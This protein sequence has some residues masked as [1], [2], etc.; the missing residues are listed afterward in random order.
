MEFDC[1]EEG[2]NVQWPHIFTAM[3][4]PFDRDGN[5]DAERAQILARWLVNHGSQGLVLA[6]TTGESPTLANR[7]RARLWEAVRTAVGADVPVLM[8]TG[9]NDTE[10]ARELSRE[11][12]QWGVDG[13]LLVTPYYNKP[14]QEGLY[15]HFLRIAD[16]LPVPVMLYNVPGRT[17]VHLEADTIRRIVADAPNVAA[18]KEA[19]GVLGNIERLLECCPET[20]IYSGDD[21][22]FYPGLTMGAHGVVSVAAH[23]VGTEMLRL[24]EAFAQGDIETARTWHLRLLPVFRGLFRLPNP[25]PVKWVLNR[26]GLEVGPVRLPLVY[27]DDETE[28]EELYTRVRAITEDPARNGEG[29]DETDRC[30]C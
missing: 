7:E 29:K 26:M 16:D 21:A 3:A 11:A 8:G 9:S 28:L 14:P 17:G 23:V 27:P 30:A 18:V 6:G 15:R 12:A 5:L 13:V 22:L 4:T 2:I 19:S 1:S 25:I 24:W 20:T 10:H